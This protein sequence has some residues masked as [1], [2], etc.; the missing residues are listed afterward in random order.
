M[1]W[2]DV[3]V[4]GPTLLLWHFSKLSE[5]KKELYLF[6]SCQVY[7]KLAMGAKLTLVL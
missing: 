1:E 4:D 2:I 7:G 3:R 6:G 5:G